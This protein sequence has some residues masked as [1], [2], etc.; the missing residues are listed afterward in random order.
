MFSRECGGG[1]KHLAGPRITKIPNHP[2]VSVTIRFTGR[3]RK[4]L[5][6][7]TRALAGT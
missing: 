6:G 1:S 7:E 5:T 2:S 4:L 3:T